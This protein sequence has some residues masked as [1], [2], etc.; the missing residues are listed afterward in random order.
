MQDTPTPY[1][2]LLV[3][4]SDWVR[5]G[6]ELAVGESAGGLTL[7][8][9]T[10]RGQQALALVADGP[11]FD[12]ALVDIGLPDISGVH[13]IRAIAERYPE[14][15]S[16][17]FTV[18][19]DAETV[20]DVVRAGARGYLLKSSTA[21][22]VIE[23]LQAA[24]QGGAPMTPRVARIVVDALHRPAVAQCSTEKEIVRGLTDREREV[25]Q[26]LATGVT[27]AQTAELLGIRLG[28]VQSHVKKIYAKLQV[29]SKTEAATVAQRAG[30][31]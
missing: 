21:P 19:D 7:A 18:F 27:Y 14:A 16:I 4:D 30:L 20:M 25:L 1:R 6:L 12:V 5:E 13:V 3:E 29:D 31:V 9:S 24:A 11:A 26:M 17:A 8:A 23:G 15:V 22:Q 2:V 10:A 28:T